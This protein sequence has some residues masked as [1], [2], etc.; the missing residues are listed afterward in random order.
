MAEGESRSGALG[1]L[2]LVVMIDMIGFGII[3]P[4][5]TYFIEDLATV[6]GVV[7]FGFWIG[8]MMMAYSSAQFLFSP[9]WGSLS[10]RI[11]R[12]PVILTGL[13][14][15]TVFFTVFGLSSSLLMALI[16][17]FL[18]GAFN[19][20]IAVA[21]AYIG[22]VSDHTNLAKRMGLIGASFGL[23]FTIGPFLGGEFSDPALRWEIFQNTIF[24]T[25]SYLLPCVIGSLLSTISFVLAIKYLPESN[26]VEIRKSSK[27][28]N[29][30]KQ[31]SNTISDLKRI[32][33]MPQL[34]NLISISVFFVY[35]FTI[36]H[37]VFVLFTELELG[38]SVAENGRIF[39]IIGINGLIIQG[40]LIGPLT[41]KF[42]SIK[43]M[44]VGTLVC[45]LGLTLVPHVSHE[46]IWLSMGAVVI[47]I[48]T[49]SGLFQPSF[50]AI[51]AQR[52]RE[53]GQEMGMVMGAQESAS[54]FSR[55][56]GPLTGGLVWDATVN[57]G[58]WFSNAT[59][60]HLCG[61]MM[62]IAFLLQLKTKPSEAPVRGHLEEC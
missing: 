53:S 57:Q 34:G 50:A 6:E 2:F 35:G 18:A 61:L 33:A 8:L 20:N 46:W 11:G 16:A 59:A 17:R 37:A 12:R 30:L 26:P 56:I 51:L 43:L 49:G 36:M 52:T 41:K 21:K 5:L 14:G 22:D 44:R 47:L 1:I 31:I 19:A 9:F 40:G 27:S 29:P 39:A 24:E 4:F 28:L 54:A 48:S 32:S 25:H 60:F 7:E 55:I 13:V 23:G 58:G 42:G 3:I 62:A 10:D 38:F 45:G 15:N